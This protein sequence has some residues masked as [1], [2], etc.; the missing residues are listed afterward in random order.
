ML[1]QLAGDKGLGTAVYSLVAWAGAMPA[2]EHSRGAATAGAI[3]REARL[4]PSLIM[5]MEKL[6]VTVVKLSKTAGVDLLRYMKKATNRDFRIKNTEVD[7]AL[8]RKQQEE[9]EG[10]GEGDEGEEGGGKK[11]KRKKGKDA[12]GSKAKKPKK[13]KKDD[14]TDEDE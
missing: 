9:E 4:V 10:E 12:G 13:S 7:H 11:P 14:D 2:G 6:E 1:T 3:K 5:E 8:R